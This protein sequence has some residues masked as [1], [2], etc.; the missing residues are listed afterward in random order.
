VNGGSNGVIQNTGNGTGLANQHTSYGIYARG[1]DTTIEN[2]TIANL[3]IHTSPA[4]IAVDQTNVQCINARGSNII[5]ANNVMHDAGWCIAY[6][7]NYGDSG[8]QVYGNTIYRIDHGFVIGPSAPGESAGT[9]NFHDN[10]IYDYSNWNT[11]ANAYH[12]DG[13][14]CFSSFSNPPHFVAF[15]IYNNSFKHSSY[16]NVTAHIY[17]EGGIGSGATPCADPESTIYIYNNILSGP[18][19]MLLESGAL[20]VYNNTMI[21]LDSL[22]SNDFIAK[23]QASVVAF[24]NNA[25]TTAHYLVGIGDAAAMTTYSGDYNSFANG[26]TYTALTFHNKSFSA[27]TFPGWQAT[28]GGDLH[29]TYSASL[30]LTN[31]GSPLAGSPVIR[32][33]ANLT[34][35][36][37]KPL[38]S[39]TSAGNTR[40]P[41][42][43]PAIGPW[44]A[45]AY[46]GA[47]PNPPS[48]LTG[49][50]K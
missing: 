26:G 45:G 46:E 21:G 25:V 14:H 4:D 40:T 19:N 31:S 33:G 50:V 32:T 35:L 2:L 8:L 5:I 16:G 34:S 1:G 29:S 17:L 43:R 38:N 48:G 28:A 24:E 22:Q 30:K 11:T 44:D 10:S 13:I 3:Y 37:I 36:G 15:N 27:G 6:T 23:G 39:D 18:S 9:F 20:Y 49:I 41:V 7:F 42:T 12:H 47:G